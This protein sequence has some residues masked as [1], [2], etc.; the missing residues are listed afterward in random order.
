[1]TSYQQNLHEETAYLKKTV[2]FI[3]RALETEADD[4]LVKKARLIAARKDMWENTVHF[5][6]DFA[7]L[8]EMNQ[9]LAEV[10]SLTAS[11]GN[12]RKQVER[13]KR[14]LGS[15]Y[16]GRFDFAE[17]GSDR[18]EK[19]Y[20]GLYNMMDSQTHDIYVYDWRAPISSIYYR[21]E[22]GPA[23]YTAP[24]GVI[25]GD[26]VLKRQYKIRDSQLKYFFD[27]SLT[28]N[29]EILQ[30]ILSGSASPK[31]RNIVETIQKEQDMIIRDTDNELL[32]VQ[33]VAGSGKTSVA[34]HR[35]AYLLYKGLDSKISSNNVMIISP[36]TVFSKYISSVLPD[37]GEENV[38]QTTFND[39]VADA[40]SDRFMVETREMHLESVI[41]SRDEGDIRRPGL[42]FKGSRAFLQILGRLLFHYEHRLIPFADIYFNG[43]LIETG[44][45]LK[46]RFL[47]NKIGIPMAK[48]LQRLEHV[49][50]EKVH[51][52]RKKR[53]RRLEKIVANSDGHDLEIKSFSRLLSMKETK[54]FMERLHRF[55]KVDYFEVYKM[56]FDRP[57][58]LFKLAQ[59]LELPEDIEQIISTTKQSLQEGMI[60]YEDCVPLLYLMLKIEGSDLFSEIRQ[61]VIDEA[62]DYSPMH[63]EV[64]KL[65]FKDAKYTVLGDIHQTIEK[66]ADASL[67]DDISE[68]LNKRKTIKLFL[69][70]GYRSSYEINSFTQKLLGQSQ[71][72]VPFERHEKEPLVEYK[73]TPSLIDE[74]IIRDTACFAEQGYESIAVICKTQQEAE[75]AHSRLNDSIKIKLVRPRDGVIEK[76]TMVIPSYLAKGLEFD[77][78]IVYG[79]D[80][81][82][83]STDYDRQLL[84]TACTRALHRLVIYHTGEKSPFI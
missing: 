47:N 43:I 21:Y 19:I 67:Y 31:M 1:M 51:P 77:V 84:Y 12:T 82:A 56:L 68:I 2:A 74:A 46:N 7:R 24:S 8:T 5:S 52:V 25:T 40:L 81:T 61:V 3:R 48:Q 70:K 69:N 79:A 44:Q 4:L 62:Q 23:A 80:K 37:L 13:Y 35:V 55:T 15:P 59:G 11:Y 17:D 49:I 29:D 72:F 26:V 28:I 58:L 73:E 65:L 10:N 27:S 36:N 60:Y 22:L 53:L 76:G 14:A 42:D 63:Y 45:Q 39:I 33:G 9:Y 78:V 41:N 30:E 38:E 16:F 18:R 32:I 54:R 50:M 75:A 20:V 6:T 57:D 71:D 34:L 83:Y 64:F 66:E